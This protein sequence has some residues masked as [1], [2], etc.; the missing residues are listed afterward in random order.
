[1]ISI[2]TSSLNNP[3]G[4]FPLKLTTKEDGIKSAT[5]KIAEPALALAITYTS[6][7]ARVP[8]NANGVPDQESVPLVCFFRV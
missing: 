3:I 4:S 1:M 6:P 5:S 7:L 8:D 2:K